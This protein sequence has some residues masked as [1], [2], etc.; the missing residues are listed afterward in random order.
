MNSTGLLLID[1]Q[2]GFD[3]PKWGVRN[4]PD[5]EK[6]IERL[7]EAWRT[8]G[9]P[10]IHVQHRSTEPDSPLRPG[11]AGCEF[12]PEGEPREGE[13]I[14]GKSVNSAFIGTSLEEHLRGNGIDHLVIAGFTTDHCVST[15][16]R[17][18]GNLGFPTI[19]VSDATATFDRK[20]LDGA[21]LSAD[22]IH[23]VHLASLNGEFCQV[24]STAEVL[25]ASTGS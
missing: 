3:D 14:F 12:K 9:Q 8:Q 17:M 25:A 4:N 21:Q 5:A 2:K 13:A 20:G 23:R 16:T 18:A 15:T 7:L 19:L 10:V 11:T 6:N 22:E 1:V 24:M